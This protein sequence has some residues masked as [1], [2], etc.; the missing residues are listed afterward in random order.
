[1]FENMRL[2]FSVLWVISVG[3]AFAFGLAALISWGGFL[4]YLAAAVGAIIVS[5]IGVILT[6]A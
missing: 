6:S 1:M 3:A 2:F 4:D 5:T